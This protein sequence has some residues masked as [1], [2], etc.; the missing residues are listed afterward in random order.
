[1]RARE[2]SRPIPLS[3]DERSL[4]VGAVPFRS[5]AFLVKGRRAR[6]AVER[7]LPPATMMTGPQTAGRAKLIQSGTME[8]LGQD[9]A[10][11]VQFV[12]APTARRRRMSNSTT[13]REDLFFVR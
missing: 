8:G 13:F 4:V 3:D 7:A 12:L 10:R 11:Y 1:M 2:E 9:V 5:R 6:G